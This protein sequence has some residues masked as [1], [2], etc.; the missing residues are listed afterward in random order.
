MNDSD[1]S[2]HEQQYLKTRIARE[3]A[4]ALLAYATQVDKCWDTG[5]MNPDAHADAYKAH[6]EPLRS[7]R[8]AFNALVAVD[9]PSA[10]QQH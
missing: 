5:L 3:V 10:Y 4:N 8:I 2:E 6:V 1:H 7:A 9:G